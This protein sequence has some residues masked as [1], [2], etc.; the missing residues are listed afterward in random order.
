[1]LGGMDSADPAHDES[2][3]AA[4]SETA[5][6]RQRRITHEA[7]LISQARA[8]VAAGR[9]VSE[10]EVDAWIDSLKTEHELPP[11]HSDP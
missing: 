5:A 6:A 7:E 4:R 2:T 11:P 10:E 8:S 9:T 1:M 3:R